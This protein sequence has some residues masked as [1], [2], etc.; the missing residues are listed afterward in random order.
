MDPTEQ[1]LRA[2]AQASQTNSRRSVLIP[3]IAG[4][5][6]TPKQGMQWV[7]SNENVFN[8]QGP[9][10]IV[11]LS[12]D[13]SG[14]IR[15]SPNTAAT[16]KTEAAAAYFQL[17][18]NMQRAGRLRTFLDVQIMPTAGGGTANVRTYN[19][20]YCKQYLCTTT[21]SAVVE[22]DT[23]IR[24]NQISD[25]GFGNYFGGGVSLRRVWDQVFTGSTTNYYISFAIWKLLDKCGVTVASYSLVY[26]FVDVVL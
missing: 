20:F 4:T 23:V 5:P 8:I 25:D 12:Q 7:N 21:P 13:T 6:Q 24:S 9:S 19:A 17:S 1:S 22:T 11:K 3:A 26:D 15:A 16:G 10:G 14:Q 18:L 2:I